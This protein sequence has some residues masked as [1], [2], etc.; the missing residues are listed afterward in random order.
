MAKDKVARLVTRALRHQPEL[1]DL[2]LDRA[3]YCDTRQLVKSLKD[4]GYPVDLSVIEKI[5]ENERFSF[6][7]DHTGIRADYGNS[8]GLL[9]K[10]MYPE[11]SRPPAVLYHGTSYEAMAG[12]REKGIIRFGVDGKKGRDHVFLTESEAVALKKGA[13]HGKGIGLPIRAQ[14]MYEAGY[15]FY[16][17][18]NDIWLTDHIPAEYIDFSQVIFN[19]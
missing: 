9:L 3:G 15:L 1:L 17:A 10:D 12:I 18:K 16:H 19:V 6:N 13:R 5:G 4:R 14:D 11:D 2:T 7:K 8:I